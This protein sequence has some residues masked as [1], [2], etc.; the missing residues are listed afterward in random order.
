LTIFIAGNHLTNKKTEGIIWN[1]RVGK[2]FQRLK[3]DQK[4]VIKALW[5]E[6][7]KVGLYSDRVLLFTRNSYFSNDHR[8]VKFNTR[9]NPR[10]SIK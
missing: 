9:N 7:F 8:L 10:I 5:I 6:K 3:K 4:V 2:C 1:Q